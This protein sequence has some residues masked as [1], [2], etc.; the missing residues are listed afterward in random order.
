MIYNILKEKDTWILGT[1]M[2][3]GGCIGILLGSFIDETDFEPDLLMKIILLIM[4][5]FCWIGM[6]ACIKY[7]DRLTVY[8]RKDD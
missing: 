1:G 4:F 7:S 8:L 5:Y 3:I 6:V 2:F